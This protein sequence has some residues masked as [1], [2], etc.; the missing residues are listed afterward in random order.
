MRKR[1][2]LRLKPTIRA[3]ASSRPEPRQPEPQPV[4]IQE[5]IR[6]SSG[7]DDLDERVFTGSDSMSKTSGLLFELPRPRVFYAP[8]AHSKLWAAVY[9]SPVEVGWLGLVDRMGNDYLIT[10]IFVPK[11]QVSSVTTDIEPEDVAV[12]VETL[13]QEGHDPSKLRFWG[14][15]HVSMDVTPSG[16]DEDQ[17]L[18]YLTDDVDW[19]IRGIYNKHGK[20]KVD[21][22]DVRNNMLHQCVD[23]MLLPNGSEVG[24][25]AAQIRRNVTYKQLPPGPHT[26][27]AKDEDSEDFG[28]LSDFERAHLMTDPFFFKGE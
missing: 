21:V 26:R 1:K 19:F 18:E 17:V 13:V 16:T 10:D 6:P 28:D 3:L 7:T 11:Q 20:A 25:I 12:L 8:E 22:Y 14:H 5:P 15:S 4:K 27:P 24:E 23:Q 9:L 2:H